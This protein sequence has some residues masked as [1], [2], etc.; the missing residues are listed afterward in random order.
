MRSKLMLMKTSKNVQVAQCDNVY[1][2][3]NTL[4]SNRVLGQ[5][6]PLSRHHYPGKQ[7]LL[8]LVGFINQQVWQIFEILIVLLVASYWGC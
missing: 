5:M 4:L 2:R 8:S 1:T 7:K 6:S 3:M